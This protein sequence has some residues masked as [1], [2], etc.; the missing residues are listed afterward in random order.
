MRRHDREITDR[1]A[2]KAILNDSDVCHLALVDEGH[3][4][5]VA[6]NYGF[7][8]LGDLPVL[9]FHCAAKGRKLDIIASNPEA[10]VS[11][12]TGH[13]LIRG[14]AGCEWGMKYRSIVGEGIVSPVSDVDERI[15]ALDLIMSHYSEKSGFTYNEKVLSVTVILKMELT[16]ISGKQKA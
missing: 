13:E 15:R 10:C 6:L 7:S 8:W 9:Y 3:P 12:D 16:A 1:D 2:L 5:V 14:E 4:Y 11:V